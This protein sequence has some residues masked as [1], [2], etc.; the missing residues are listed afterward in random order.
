MV[1]RGFFDALPA[2]RSG[3]V[4][5][6]EIELAEAAQLRDIFPERLLSTDEPATAPSVARLGADVQ[7]HTFPPWAVR[8]RGRAQGLLRLA[9]WRFQDS[10]IEIE[11]AT[12]DRG[13]STLED[14]ATGLGLAVDW[15]FE[16]LELNRVEAFVETFDA[17]LA[18]MLGGRGFRLEACLREWSVEAGKRRHMNVFA[19][20][21]G[22]W[23]RW[24]EQ[25]NDNR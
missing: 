23:R 3:P 18:T 2:L 7:S 15:A 5:L 16:Q 4:S 24:K 6:E 25:H 10:R 17:E 8:A 14:V 12:L 9:N 13:P 11:I 22:E 20:L 21:A 19:L 1:N